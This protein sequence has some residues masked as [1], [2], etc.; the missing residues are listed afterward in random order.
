MQ[1]VVDTQKIYN[2]MRANG[3]GAEADAIA[4]GE[5][6]LGDFCKVVNGAGTSLA[7]IPPSTGQPQMPP[8]YGGPLD[9]CTD[10]VQYITTLYTQQCGLC[11]LPCL[12]RWMA[13]AVMETS[14]AETRDD[15]SIPDLALQT[16]GAT[17]TGLPGNNVGTT[18]FTAA[19]PVLPN[20]S[21]LLRVQTYRLPFN[22][23]CLWGALGFSGGTDD[24]NFRHVIFK[25]WV[26]PRVIPLTGFSMQDGTLKEWAPKRWI[27]GS[28]FRC[29]DGCNEIP[30]RS[31]TGCTDA[32][33]VGINSTFYVQI[34]N[35]GTATFNI[36]G[37]QMVVKLGGFVVPCCD[38]CGRGQACASGC[39]GLKH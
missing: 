25:V 28:Q 20:F 38:P 36:T 9:S 24:A 16:T 26:G 4:R 22:P 8:P 3:M 21:I 19:F 14:L 39:K 37:Q 18:T 17:P 32:D 1:V 27:Y 6:A 12:A 33:I 5:A 10:L 30:L 35:L 31:F 23:R 2:V 13:Y 15:F 11:P 34:D 7:Q 29:G